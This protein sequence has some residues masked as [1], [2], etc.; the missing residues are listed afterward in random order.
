MRGRSHRHEGPRG[1]A[2]VALDAVMDPV[3]WFM[4]RRML[5]GIKERAEAASPHHIGAATKGT[6]LGRADRAL[7]GRLDYQVARLRQ[8]D[9]PNGANPV[10]EADLEPLPPRQSDTCSGWG[11]WAIRVSARSEH[12]SLARSACGRTRRG[13]PTTRG[14]TTNPIR[15]HD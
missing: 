7:Q 9:L 4:T 13:C 3:T 10:S 5:L 1:V 15:S 14:N 12:V 6:A 8:P 11:C 2:D